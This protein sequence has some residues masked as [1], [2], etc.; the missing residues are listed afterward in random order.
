MEIDFISTPPM[1][2]TNLDKT[3]CLGDNAFYLYR[4]KGVVACQKIMMC[5]EMSS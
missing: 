5:Q 4:S 1:S 3:S 2:I